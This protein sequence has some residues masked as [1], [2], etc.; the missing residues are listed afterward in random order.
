RIWQAGG[1]AAPVYAVTDTAF[2]IATARFQEDGKRLI[3][4]LDPKSRT[5]PKGAD[6]EAEDHQGDIGI[7]PEPAEKQKGGLLQLFG[8]KGN[9]ARIDY[10]D[11]EGG[12]VEQ[13]FETPCLHLTDASVSPDGK[14]AVALD[15]GKAFVIP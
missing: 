8:K 11:I 10:W 5:K 13:T 4:G 6:P 3:V 14:F 15:P 9:R 12:K 2:Q 7:D 1:K